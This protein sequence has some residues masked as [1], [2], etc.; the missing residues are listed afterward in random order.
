M[1]YWVNVLARLWAPRC[2]AAVSGTRSLLS[3]GDVNGMGRS[4][5]R[6]RRETCGFT[7]LKREEEE[8][9]EKEEGK[10][11]RW[12]SHELKY[13]SVRLATGRV[14]VVYYLKCELCASESQR[15]GNFTSGE[16]YLAVIIV[17]TSNGVLKASGLR[18]VYEITRNTVKTSRGGQNEGVESC[19]PPWPSP[20]AASQLKVHRSV[21]I[22]AGLLPCAHVIIS[23]LQ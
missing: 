23:S 22:I 13:P 20:V 19:S 1:Y 21:V 7:L 18:C 9:E 4:R 16:V 5:G 10:Q 14:G 6:L 17:T 15:G 2:A 3:L 12:A 8:E 11:T